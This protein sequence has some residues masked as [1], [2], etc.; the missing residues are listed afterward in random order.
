[1]AQYELYL[2]NDRGRRLMP[3]TNLRSFSAAKMV[4]ATAGFSAVLRPPADLPTLQNYHYIE[5]NIRKDWQVQVWF[6]SRGPWR[7]F[8]AYLVL[9]WGWGQSEDG[10]EVF[11][12]GG[13]DM[14]HLLTRRV[15]A[16]YTGSAQTFMTDYADDMMKA[17]VTDSMED[18]ALP[19]PTTGSR[20]WAD[21]TVAAD[22][23]KGPS[24]SKGFSWNPLLT[25]SGSGA[26]ED[27]AL[28]ARQGGNPVYFRIAPN[29]ISTG[30]TTWQFRTQTGQP[31]AD[32]T[33]GATQVVFDADK[34]T[35]VNWSLD[36][37]YSEEVNAVYGLGQGKD[38]LRM[39]RQVYDEPRTKSS[40]WG[41]CESS[42]EA[43]DQETEDGVDNIANGTL[44]AGRPRVTL[45]GEPVSRQGQAFM[46]HWGW[47]DKVIARAKGKQFQALVWSVVVSQDE[48]SK[49][50]E[51]ARLEFQE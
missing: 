41:R 45:R 1:M 51:S 40:Y 16:A 36:Y 28:P 37:D 44:T 11:S 5:R 30:A 17:V 15:V 39:V 8:A 20:A 32:R 19:V 14:N 23:S 9:D 31:L 43:Q 2:C 4:N 38:D 42:V 33:S 18:D 27:I 26:L 6:K 3:L 13:Y 46:R 24:F 29:T 25:L 49:V 47:G 50:T 35:L 12:F 7:L 22:L 10:E 34:G 21:L 48:D